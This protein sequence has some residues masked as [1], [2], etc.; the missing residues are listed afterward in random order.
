M[1][2]F[3]LLPDSPQHETPVIDQGAFELAGA[4]G[5]KKRAQDTTDA[6][7]AV[8][9]DWSHVDAAMQHMAGA[10]AFADSRASGQNLSAGTETA[11]QQDSGTEVPQ[12][13]ASLAQALMNKGKTGA[14]DAS[15]Q[16]RANAE[17]QSQ[18]MALSTQLQQSQTAAKMQK[19]Q[20]QLELQ[21]QK[22][23]ISNNLTQATNSL[24]LTQASLK[25]AYNNALASAKNA[26]DAL[27]L[28]A[29]YTNNILGLQ[30]ASMALGAAG[31]ATAA[32]AGRKP[33]TPG[34]PPAAP[35]A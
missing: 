13:A 15:A 12:T 29:S 17:Q 25:N 28:G 16:A 14:A 11:M 3:G 22:F 19:V 2:L 10:G 5:L 33:T 26:T 20:M 8:Q 6:A 32:L 34:A 21:N 24:S 31:A 23:D 27:N 35:A 30:S 1:A 9:F 18:A 7:N 4:D